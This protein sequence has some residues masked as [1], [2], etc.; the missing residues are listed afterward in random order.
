MYAVIKTGGKQYRVQPG[1]LLVVEKLDGEPGADVAFGD[2]LMLGD[3]DTVTLGAPVVDGA[4]VSATLIETRKGEKVKIF[5][6][7]RRQ[8][9]RRTR[10]HRQ[11]ESVLR[12]TA[13]AGAGK[14]AKWDGEVDLTPKAVLDARARGLNIEV[15]APVAAEAK[16]AKAAP[17]KAAKATEAEAEAPAAE[18][19]KAAPK[20]AAAP[21]ADAGE[22]KAAPKKA[23]A[24]KESDA[25]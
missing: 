13:I 19:K 20:K 1:D 25:E 7:I 8:G 6:K 22:K 23:A 18:A 16:P 17:K 10:G 5:K 4:S 9:Y 21:K 3:G 15:A 14:T 12:V 24:K 11:L 2:V